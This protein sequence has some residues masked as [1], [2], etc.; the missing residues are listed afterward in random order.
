MA[1][2]LGRAN[3]IT[4]AFVVVFGQ[5]IFLGGSNQAPCPL[6][7]IVGVIVKEVLRVLP[8]VVESFSQALPTCA[9]G[10]DLLLEALLKIPVSFWTL[11][12]ALAGA[13]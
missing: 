11:I 2:D 4:Y 9:N 1:R 3:S 8:S 6:T 5:V 10:Q 13:A 12:S 7:D